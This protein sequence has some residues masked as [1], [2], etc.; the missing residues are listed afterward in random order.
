MEF[1]YL[2]KSYSLIFPNLKSTQTPSVD[3]VLIFSHHLFPVKLTNMMDALVA[4]ALKEMLFWYVI[5]HINAI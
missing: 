3:I 1:V 5:K 4:T 2:T